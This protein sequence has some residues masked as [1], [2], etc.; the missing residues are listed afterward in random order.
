MNMKKL[1][2]AALAVCMLLCS[3]GLSVLADNTVAMIG[4]A[5]FT[6]LATAISTANAATDTPVTITLTDDI[7]LEDNTKFSITGDVILD[8]AGH[9]ID[10][11]YNAPNFYLI[12][13]TGKLT[14]NDS[15]DTHS[16][17]LKIDDAS[18]SSYLISVSATGELVINGGTFSS[19][20]APISCGNSANAKIT[21][22][23]GH[24]SNSWY[25][26]AIIMRGNSELTINDGVIENTK[27]SNVISAGTGSC[28]ITIKGGTIGASG[29][30][31]TS[32]NL[33]GSNT[34]VIEGG[35]FSTAVSVG[36]TDT[37]T[38]YDGTFTVT[39]T[40]AVSAS[41]NA[42]VTIYGGT[43]TST[44]SNPL[45]S[46]SGNAT[47]TVVDGDFSSSSSAV[48]SALGTSTLN[49]E[50]GTF[51]ATGG[52]NSTLSISSG[53]PTVNISGGTLSSNRDTVS[54]GSGAGAAT[55]NISGGN[56][57][58]ANTKSINVSSSAATV[59]VT[60]GTFS[61]DVTTYIPDG[62][63][64]DTSTG[65]FVVTVNAADT[66]RVDFEQ[67]ET[68]ESGRTYR[69]VL[70]PDADNVLIN[71]LNSADLTFSN[72]SDTVTY[73][74]AKISDTIAVN[75]VEGDRY[76][77][78]FNTKTDIND[79]DTGAAVVI[80]QVVF[81]GYGDVNFSIADA[82]TNAV[83]ATAT[84]D[85]IVTTY[86]VDGGTADNI[87]KL[88]IDGE[89]STIETTFAEATRSLNVTIHYNN[90]IQAG[91]AAAYNDMTVTVT[92][93]NGDEYVGKVGTAD[94][95][96][97]DTTVYATDYTAD[98]ASFTFDVK[99]GYRYTVT[100]T[101]AGYRTARY[102]TL[103][104]SEETDPV[105]LTFWNNVKDDAAYVQEGVDSSKMTS[106]FLAGDI[107][108]DNNINIYD[109][110]AVVSYFG[111][112]TETDAAS[113]YAKYDL[114]RDGVIDSKDVA[115][116]LVSWEN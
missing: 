66:I 105:A 45:V 50:D 37:A 30:S 99:A 95:A 24:I 19:A 22:N 5:E 7:L 64:V 3:A 90:N 98:A 83:H 101:G 23:G 106:N 51:A 96:E 15:S 63:Q 113:Q 87:G 12:D 111:T 25:N 47:L 58:S 93:A 60:G 43:Y 94:A 2:S 26:G 77:F 69:I 39:K 33:N 11:T 21:I 38:I 27:N 46:V 100:V 112:T 71:R 78:H 65:S 31:G 109:L 36:G 14:V 10:L 104:G 107:V 6:S 97:G 56:L 34:L 70:V 115:L 40:A 80:G 88:V 79:A 89:N 91:N 28:A 82:D 32:V 61:S 49:V 1:F 59:E 92:G 72:L 103:V 116:V 85:N 55:V 102:T 74:I 48:L 75:Q 86:L 54:V 44:Y 29:S 73:Q 16:G 35:T 42:N 8:L 76:E 53:T 67:D 13:V 18:T 20:Q 81:S 114:N 62:Y 110:S 84:S 108:A 4:T 68:D 52:Y 17:T 9:T 57:S 41:S